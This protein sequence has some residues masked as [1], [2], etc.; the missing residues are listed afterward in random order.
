LHHVL[1]RISQIVNLVSRFS[2]I[3]EIIENCLEEGNF[4][5]GLNSN[6]FDDKDTHD[7]KKKKKNLSRQRN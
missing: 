4:I 3:L 5:P 1:V 7:D 6:Y 2:G